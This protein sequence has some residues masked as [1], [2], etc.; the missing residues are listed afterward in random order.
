MTETT[1][2]AQDELEKAIKDESPEKANTMLEHEQEKQSLA[3]PPPSIN[4][5]QLP[6]SLLDRK[7]RRQSQKF[8]EVNG[9]IK[10]RKHKHIRGES[11]GHE[12]KR[13]S[14]EISPQERRGL[15]QIMEGLADYLDQKENPYENIS[16]EHFDQASGEVGRSHGLEP[17]PGEIKRDTWQTRINEAFQSGDYKTI[18]I[19]Q[20]VTPEVRPS[21]E[22]VKAKIHTLVTTRRLRWMI[23][24]RYSKPVA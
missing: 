3:E 15:S 23:G 4:H 22:L 8:T 17:M 1:Q 12:V 6:D 20:R 18:R 10:P 24:L 16:E 14:K 11:D 19:L 7:K 5:T 2:L 13:E 21:A 9:L